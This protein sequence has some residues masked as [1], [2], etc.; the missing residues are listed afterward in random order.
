MRNV[1][2]SCPSCGAPLKFK[3]G[4]RTCLCEYC[5][6]EVLATEFAF[7]VDSADAPS[8]PVVAGA[9]FIVEGTVLV[10]YIGRGGDVVIP[11]RITEIAPQA[12]RQSDVETV[13]F[14]ASLEKIGWSAF[15]EC[16]LLE[17]VTIPEGVESIGSEAFSG[18]DSLKS[19]QLPT[20]LSVIEDGVFGHCSSLERIVVPEGVESI[21]SGAF[22]WCDSLVAVTLPS[23]I[24]YLEDIGDAFSSCLS[25][26]H[27]SSRIRFKNYED[28]EI[29]SAFMDCPVLET[30]RRRLRRCIYC[31]DN[32]EPGSDTCEFC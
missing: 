16:R 21:G 12:F 5:G 23:T 20:T 2:K 10:E 4:S 9:D 15:E 31:G 28:Y 11:D 14:P 8:G 19:V 32:A 1:A 13:S 17:S 3:E 24:S 6:S 25:L 29:E 22:S 27:V 30:L 26:E 18:C 7:S